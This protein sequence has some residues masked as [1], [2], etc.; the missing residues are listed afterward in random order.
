[1]TKIS[2]IWYEKF[3]SSFYLYRTKCPKSSLVVVILIHKTTNSVDCCKTLLGWCIMHIRSQLLVLTSPCVTGNP[4]PRPAKHYLH[5]IYWFTISFVWWLIHLEAL[6]WVTQ[7]STS[8]LKIQK[9]CFQCIM[10]SLFCV[11]RSGKK[12]EIKF[13]WVLT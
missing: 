7:L 10:E 6:R 3:S 12:R 1:M 2:C 5:V 11:H 8:F 13:Q 9:T 4:L